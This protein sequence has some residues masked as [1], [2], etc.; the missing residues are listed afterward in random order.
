MTPGIGEPNDSPAA[1]SWLA[2]LA[3]PPSTESFVFTRPT[4]EIVV[5][6]SCPVPRVPLQDGE[7]AGEWREEDSPMSAILTFILADFSDEDGATMVEY[8]IMVAVVA[9]IVLIGATALGIAVE[10]IFSDAAATF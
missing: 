5:Q 9:L 3:R 6:Y 8:G 7:E 10:A 1:P 4:G 2:E